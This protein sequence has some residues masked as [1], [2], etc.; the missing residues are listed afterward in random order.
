MTNHPRRSRARL[1]DYGARL[2]T[3]D[4]VT[5]VEMIDPNDNSRSLYQYRREAATVARRVLSSNGDIITDWIALAPSEL[6]ALMSVRGQYHPILDPLGF[7]GRG[8]VGTRGST[9]PG[10]DMNERD[11]MIDAGR[12]VRR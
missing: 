7:L 4:G 3:I 6:A 8:P 1:A 12:P 5:V 11:A 2:R 9:V 10:P